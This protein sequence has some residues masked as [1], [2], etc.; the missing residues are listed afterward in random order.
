MKTIYKITLLAFLMVINAKAQNFEL[1]P[2]G[3]SAIQLQ[4]EGTAEQLQAQ[5]Y[6]AL[7]KVYN[8]PKAISQAGS[9]LVANG[10]S[11]ARVR[12]NGGNVFDL[13]YSLTFSF[14]DNTIII[15]PKV[16]QM[17]TLG[18]GL[19]RL[20]LVINRTA[21]NKAPGT[22]GIYHDSK[23]KSKTAKADLESYLNAVI[24]LFEKELSNNG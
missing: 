21:A 9:I 18:V 2:A 14:I 16:L 24:T 10:N 5:A 1:S 7:A 11:S 22:F 8:S 15:T 12:R 19:D 23:L 20:N 6:E 13:D 4:Y 3:L 17:Q